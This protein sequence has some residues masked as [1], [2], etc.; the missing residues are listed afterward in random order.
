MTEH[1]KPSGV[2]GPTRVIVGRAAIEPCRISFPK[3]KRDIEMLFARRFELLIREHSLVGYRLKSRIIQN[4]EN[5]FDFTLETESGARYLEL[6]EYAP[7]KSSGITYGSAPSWQSTR[8]MAEALIAQVIAKAGHY[9]RA[10]PTPITL[11]AYVTDFKFSLDQAQI[12][13]VAYHLHKHKLPFEYVFYLRPVDEHD[14]QVAKLYPHPP[15]CFAS[16][17]PDALPYEQ[18]LSADLSKFHFESEEE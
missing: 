18:V 4:E 10:V 15:S 16:F 6:M 11:L 9:S 2:I 1:K 3:E 14:S 17:D 12:V 7:V 8:K 5:D 13:F